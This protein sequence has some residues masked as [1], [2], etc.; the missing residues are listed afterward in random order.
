MENY[1][2]IF[3]FFCVVSA[4]LF[5]VAFLSWFEE[6]KYEKLKKKLHKYDPDKY[7]HIK[8]GDDVFIHLFNKET[9]QFELIE[10]K[11]YEIF[12]R[13]VKYKIKKL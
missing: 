7:H 4:F 10:D 6:Y 2:G 5:V 9:Q 13:I 12:K 3:V 1:K 8:I 11:E